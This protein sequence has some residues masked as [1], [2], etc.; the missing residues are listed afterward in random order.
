MVSVHSAVNLSV[1]SY[2]SVSCHLPAIP[3]DYAPSPAF[4]LW[5]VHQCWPSWSTLLLGSCLKIERGILGNAKMNINLISK[6][7]KKRVMGESPEYFPDNFIWK[8]LFILKPLFIALGICTTYVHACMC[9]SINL[10]LWALI[11]LNHYARL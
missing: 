1:S 9:S 2:T 7:K 6:E 3:S 10:F 8:H 11:K 5:V 4:D